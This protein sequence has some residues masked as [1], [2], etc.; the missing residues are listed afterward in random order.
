M[1]YCEKCRVERKWPEGFMKSHGRC[2]C[3]DTVA[4]CHD[5]PSRSLPTPQETGALRALEKAVKK[6]ER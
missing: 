3:C 4:Y 5:R 2:E 6:G 1:F